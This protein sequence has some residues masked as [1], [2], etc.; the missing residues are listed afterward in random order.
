MKAIYG[1]DGLRESRT[2]S[3]GNQVFYLYDGMDPVV[4]FSSAGVV[5]VVNTFGA[6][7]VLARY[8][9]YFAPS[10][11]YERFYAFDPQGNCAEMI[12]GV[13]TSGTLLL[14]ATYDAFGAQT[15]SNSTYTDAFANYGGQ[16]GYLEDADGLELLGHRYY[17]EVNGRFVNWDPA[18]YSGSVGL[19]TY[20]G[21]M[22]PIALDP[23]GLD[24][25]CGPGWVPVL[26]GREP[27]W[28]DACKTLG[29]VIGA[30]GGLGW[31]KGL[32]GGKYVTVGGGILVIIGGVA[33]LIYLWSPC[34]PK[35]PAGWPISS[36]NP[37][38]W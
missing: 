21:D 5:N 14:S 12:A 20:C 10:G 16:C 35:A 9:V 8:S 23:R 1:F 15:P 19:Y 30:G 33:H 34:I 24:G 38:Q 22:P 7:G 2:D 3:N 26:P 27:K 11:D 28:P 32:P 25:N 17:D 6:N 31:W 36:Y 13:D 37:Y 18:G 4:Q 29:A